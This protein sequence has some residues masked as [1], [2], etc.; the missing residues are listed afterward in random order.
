MVGALIYHSIENMSRLVHKDVAD[1]E[2]KS[3]MKSQLH[4]T[5]EYMKFY[6]CGHVGINDEVRQNTAF[7]IHG[8]GVGA[9]QYAMSTCNSCMVPFQVLTYIETIV[10]FLTPEI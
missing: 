4:A 10:N 9:I 6:C 2:R 1:D 3:I 7:S 8:T 5:V